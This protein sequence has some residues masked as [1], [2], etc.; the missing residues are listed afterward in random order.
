MNQQIAVDKI[1]EIIVG[2]GERSRRDLGS[3]ELLPAETLWP[4]KEDGE[5]GQEVDLGKRGIG[6]GGRSVSD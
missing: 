6:L 1:N 5:L 3:D 4:T 2:V